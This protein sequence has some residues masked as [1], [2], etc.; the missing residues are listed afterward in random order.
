MRLTQSA[1]CFGAKLGHA[2]LHSLT[3]CRRYAVESKARAQS[4]WKAGLLTDVVASD[5]ADKDDLTELT[6]RLTAAAPLLF[7]HGVTQ[8]NAAPLH[9][10]ASAA[11]LANA[12]CAAGRIKPLK[13]RDHRDSHSECCSFDDSRPY[14]PWHDHVHDSIDKNAFIESQALNGDQPGSPDADDA[15]EE[16]KKRD[17]DDRRKNP[18]RDEVLDGID[19]HRA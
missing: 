15:T 19:S 13:A 11:V 14:I 6:V 8:A 12:A 9:D 7:E 5:L 4:A 2:V 1:S 10:G 18:W 16:A 17:H 3:V